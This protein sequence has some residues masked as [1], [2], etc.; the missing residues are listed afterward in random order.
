MDAFCVV[1]QIAT[2][3]GQ[4]PR[5]LGKT[6]VVENNLSPKWAQKIV[7]D[8]ELGTPSRLAVSV[9]HHK[10]SGESVSMGAALF[11]VGN[12]LGCRGSTKAKKVKGGGTLYATMRQSEGSGSLRLKFRGEKVRTSVQDSNRPKQKLRLTS[13]LLNLRS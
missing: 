11:D 3:N 1:T 12:T 6:E 10:S 9:F 4:T 5:V 2:Q 13:F 8:Y 7:F